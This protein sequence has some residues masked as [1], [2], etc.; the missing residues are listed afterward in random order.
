MPWLRIAQEVKIEKA[1]TNQKIGKV[2]GIF[3]DSENLCWSLPE[4]K[5]WK[6]VKAILYCSDGNLVDLLTMPKLVGRLND[7]SLM[8]TFLNGFKWAI[9]DDLSIRHENGGN[10][11]LLSANSINDL[12]IWLG[13]LMDPIVWHPITP[14]L[15]GPTLSFKYFISDAAGLSSEGKFSSGPGVASVGFNE[16]GNF[17]FAQQMF[18]PEHMIVHKKDE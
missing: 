13:F 4:E 1:F 10:P 6:T 11:I 8:C 3:F 5:R 9:L 12:R 14:E 17:I 18:W 16:R 2:L 7:I 15:V